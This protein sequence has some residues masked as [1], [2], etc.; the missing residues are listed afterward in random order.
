M[1]RKYGIYFR[2]CDKLRELFFFR[3]VIIYE[4]TRRE[5]DPQPRTKAKREDHYDEN[6][7]DHN[8]HILQSR[9]AL[10]R[11]RKGARGGVILV[12]LSYP[13][14]NE[15]DPT[16]VSCCFLTHNGGDDWEFKELA[17]FGPYL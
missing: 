9:A 11:M 5:P 10:H 4:E 13:V 16:V 3:C 1:Q 2:K 14:R 17:G 8:D 12:T 15:T 7:N 6:Q